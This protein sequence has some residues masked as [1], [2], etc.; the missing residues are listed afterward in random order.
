MRKTE[1]AADFCCFDGLHECWSN[2]DHAGNGNDDDDYDNVHSADDNIDEEE[3]DDNVDDACSA[4][5]CSI[6]VWESTS[7]PVH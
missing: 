1:A 4:L 5:Q 7:Y 6:C 2:D 3:D